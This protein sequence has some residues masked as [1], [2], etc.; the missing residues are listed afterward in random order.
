[1]CGI[2]QR[3]ADPRHGAYRV[4]PRPQVRLHSLTSS[5]RQSD[6]RFRAARFT[7][8]LLRQARVRMVWSGQA[9]LLSCCWTLS[10]GHTDLNH[11]KA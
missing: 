9:L 8:Q 5:R 10:A 4:G 2:R 11:D 6:T 3:V 1:M 7:L